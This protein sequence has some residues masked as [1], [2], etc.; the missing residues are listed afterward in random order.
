[1]TLIDDLQI[2]FRKGPLNEFGA[3]SHSE[4]IATDLVAH[5]KKLASSFGSKK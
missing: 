4:S 2:E 1:V 5:Q 3:P